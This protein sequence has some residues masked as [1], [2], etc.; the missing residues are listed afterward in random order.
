MFKM[1]LQE[2]CHKNL[3]A[4]PRYT[5]IRE[6]P[7]HAA[8]FSASVLVDGKMFS[9]SLLFSSSKEAQNE[10]ARLALIHF[11]PYPS[12]SRLP[13]SRFVP[14]SGGSSRFREN[15]DIEELMIQDDDDP[16]PKCHSPAQS[17]RYDSPYKAS[18]MVNGR[19]I[20]NSE[21]FSNSKETKLDGTFDLLSLETGLQMPTFYYDVELDGEI[22]QG[23]GAKCRKQAEINAARI[24]YNHLM[25]G[26]QAPFTNVF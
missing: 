9:S 11:T 19:N 12:S 16:S 7:D 24:S 1:K 10:A 5:T 4:L 13:S 22:F 3:W 26:N 2:L 8:R 14:I 6:G 20:K 17:P 25:E 18:S 15:E 21:S 23:G